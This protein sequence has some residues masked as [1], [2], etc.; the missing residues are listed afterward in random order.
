MRHMEGGGLRQ[1]TGEKT[2][3]M[4]RRAG[5]SSAAQRS[6]GAGS[7]KQQ[8]QA[9]A[10][11]KTTGSIKQQSNHPAAQQQQAAKQANSGQQQQQEEMAPHLAV[12]G[13][14]GRSWEARGRTA[15]SFGRRQWRAAVEEE[16]GGTHGF[17]FVVQ[18]R[19]D[20][21]EPVTAPRAARGGG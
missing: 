14:V 3:E 21:A 13:R 11:S 18:R 2:G 20:D 15:A 19:R 10:A 4:R 7:S 9:A 12:P 1:D 8:R 5:E 17:E 6:A 16:G